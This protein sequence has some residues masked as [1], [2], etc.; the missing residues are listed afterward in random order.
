MSQVSTDNES[1]VVLLGTLNVKLNCSIEL[2]NQIGPDFSSLLVNWKRNGTASQTNPSLSPQVTGNLNYTNNFISTL[3]LSSVDYSNS[4][5]YCCNVSLSGSVS[6]LTDCVF[7]TV[8]GNYV[9]YYFFL[10][11]GLSLNE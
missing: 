7:L 9:D 11:C 10:E 6:N 4:G 5:N 2:S 8:S 3:T 1:V